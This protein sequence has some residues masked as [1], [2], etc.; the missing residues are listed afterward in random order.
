MKNDM[1]ITPLQM[2][3]SKILVFII[4]CLIF[5]FA[6]SSCNTNDDAGQIINNDPTTFEIISNSP[7]H[8]ILENALQSSELVELLNSGVFTV[9]APTDEAFAN[10]DVNAF[11]TAELRNVLLNHVITGN[12]ES[13]D[14]SNG[15]YKTNATETYSG[16]NN[17]ID[18]YINVDGGVLL[19]GNISVSQTDITANNGTVHVTDQVATLPSIVT[20]AVANPDFSSLETALIQEN[21]VGT[22]SSGSPPAPFTVFAPSDTAFQNF[23]DEDSEDGFETIEDLLGFNSLTD[24]LTYHCLGNAAVRS[25]MITTTT[26]TE[27]LQGENITINVDNGISITDQNGRSVN[28]VATDVTGSN[29]V[30]HVLDNVILPTLP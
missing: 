18:M 4:L 5:L 3:I 11:S 17:F 27:T 8:T 21:L 29:G 10:I 16:D 15:F 23:L 2:K 19:N 14:L 9:F 25:D 30:I 22:L 26:T 7:N 6:I 1:G 13:T 28:V 12:V 20:L 24:V